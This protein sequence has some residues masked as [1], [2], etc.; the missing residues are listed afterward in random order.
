MQIIFGAIPDYLLKNK[1]YMANVIAKKKKNVITK[2]PMEQF[3][4]RNKV[5]KGEAQLGKAIKKIW[6]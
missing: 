4:Y 5:K 2:K 3:S 1:T 6:K